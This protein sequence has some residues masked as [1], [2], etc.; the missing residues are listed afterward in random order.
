MYDFM[1]LCKIQALGIREKHRICLSESELD[2]FF[3]FNSTVRLMN[4]LIYYVF[5]TKLGRK[6]K[7]LWSNPKSEM[8]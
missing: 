7:I 3:F 8:T 6:E 2:L 1:Y 4:G 5:M